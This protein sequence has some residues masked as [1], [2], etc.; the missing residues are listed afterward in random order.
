MT[1]Q[2]L[3]QHITTNLHSIYGNREA[4]HIAYILLVEIGN[5]NKVDF[6]IHKNK[7]VNNSIEQKVLQ[8]LEL[9]MTHK[10][11]QQ[12]MGSAWF[13][14]YKFFVD[15]NVLIPRPETEELVE[16]VIKENKKVEKIIDIGTGSG[17]IAISL[18]KQIANSLV[19]AIDTS[20]K[21]LQVATKNA[22]NIEANVNFLAL[23]FLEEY[24]WNKLEKYDL[25]VSNP[26]YITYEEKAE[27]KENVLQFEPHL[28]L[29]T[30]NNN[31]L[32][33]YRKIV[34]FANNHLNKN[35]KVY[36]EINE[37]LGKETLAIFQNNNFKAELIKDLQ[38]KDRI[39]KAWKD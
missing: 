22:T 26:P 24:N 9:L 25:I 10:P 15:E 36:V 32:I 20:Y 23:D 1:W 34:L 27:M 18:Q 35:G 37:T 13:Y 14:K 8:A 33:F 16:L 21:A 19:T 6:I 30:P 3:Q 39:I 7:E 2:Q 28:A 12:V 11:I 4:Q 5:I 17:C 38:Q 31:A 29:F